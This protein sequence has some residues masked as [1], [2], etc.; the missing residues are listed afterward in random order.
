MLAA[1]T[2]VHDR[3]EVFVMEKTVKSLISWLL[4]VVL[5]LSVPVMADALSI[6]RVS[7]QILRT[8]IL[9][10]PGAMEAD[11]R[12]RTVAVY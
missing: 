11:Q 3:M 6:P 5:V 10:I 7:G 12:I 4:L 9:E 1:R 2:Y 8:E